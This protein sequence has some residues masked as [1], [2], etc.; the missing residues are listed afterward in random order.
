MLVVLLLGFLTSIFWEIPIDPVASKA[1][2]VAYEVDSVNEIDEGA[3]S[4]NLAE[5]A[6]RLI[7]ILENHRADKLVPEQFVYPFETDGH[8][9]MMSVKLVPTVD[10]SICRFCCPKLK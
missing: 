3:F 4:T 6:E 5:D 7:Y 9:L 1:Y 2:I 8:K 10:E